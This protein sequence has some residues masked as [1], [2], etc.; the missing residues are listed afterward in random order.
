MAN[1]GRNKSAYDREKLEAIRKAVN[2]PN[3]EERYKA[4][5]AAMHKASRSMYDSK[6]AA[7]MY[8]A[9]SLANAYGNY[10]EEANMTVDMIGGALGDALTAEQLAAQLE[11]VKGNSALLMSLAYQ[12]NDAR[13]AEEETEVQMGA[14]ASVDA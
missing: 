7:P 14:S 11:V 1:I 12:H 8:G 4:Q 5:Q 10:E 3:A 6:E 2:G 13:R 9:N